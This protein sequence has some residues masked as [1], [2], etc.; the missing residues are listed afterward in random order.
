[1]CINLYNKALY[2]GVKAASNNE[3]RKPPYSLESLGEDLLRKWSREYANEEIEAANK[4][5]LRGYN[6]LLEERPKVQDVFEKMLSLCK[7]ASAEGKTSWEWKHDLKTPL[8][9]HPDTQMPH[10]YDGVCLW[11]GTKEIIAKLEAQGLDV[12]YDDGYDWYLPGPAT[13]RVSWEENEDFDSYRH[14][15][16][17]KQWLNF[18]DTLPL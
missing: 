18:S 2:A 8:P 6:W 11:S 10:M 4:D 7:E 1:M 14:V 5:W 9:K 3:E 12:Y 16:K 13:L 15:K 17:T